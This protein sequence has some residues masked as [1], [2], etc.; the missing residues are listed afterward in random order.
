VASIATLGLDDAC[1]F[2]AA[3]E[4]GT[5]G[6]WSAAKTCADLPSEEDLYKEK[7]PRRLEK[8]PALSVFELRWST[9]PVLSFEIFP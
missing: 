6:P 8:L 2:A 9:R 3:F 7:D 1:V 4:E 5:R